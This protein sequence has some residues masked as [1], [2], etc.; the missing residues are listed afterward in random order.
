MLLI[1]KQAFARCG[2]MGN[3]SDGYHGRTL[4]LVVRDFR[5]EVTLYEWDQIEVVFSRHDQTRFHAIDELVRDVRL[6]GYYGG[7]RLVKA[8]IKKF[9]DYCRRQ[10]YSLHG[11]NFSVRYD[12]TVPRQVGLAGSSAI[13]VATLRCLMEFYGIEIPRQVQPS[14]VLSVET[15]EL[16]IAA[17]LQDRVVQTY[18]GLVYMDFAQQRMQQI[19]GFSCGVYEPLDPGLLPPLYVAYSTDVGEPTEV[20]HNSLRA[21]YNAGETAVVEAMARFADLTVEARGALEAGDAAHLGRLIDANFDL[22]RSICPLPPGQVRMVECAR[23]AGATA[24]FAGSGG[25]IIG[26][27]ADEATFARLQAELGRIG[28]RVIRPRVMA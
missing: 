9:V 10:G 15:E 2:L 26:T 5:A 23:A 22:R 4:A 24:K 18:E 21:R 13:I 14:L 12:S 6:H 20:T 11:E 27:F 25:A 19:G 16:G 3:P 17:G 28:C 8:T 7:I 1:R